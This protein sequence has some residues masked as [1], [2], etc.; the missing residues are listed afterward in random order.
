MKKSGRNGRSDPPKRR[1][2]KKIS[3]LLALPA[4]LLLSA[5]PA[6]GQGNPNEAVTFEDLGFALRL[7]TGARAA[8]LAGAYTSLGDD[9]HTLV[10][11]P[12]GLARVRRIEFSIGFQDQKK[13]LKS[14]FFGTQ[15][16]VEVTN[17]NL[18]FIA[19][20]YP[21][22]TYRG[23]FVL[24]GGVYR[25]MS[26][27][28]DILNRGTNTVTQTNDDYRLQQSGSI[29]RYN[30]GFGLDLS[31]YVSM[32]VTVFGLDGSLSALTQYSF[33]FVTPSLPG[34]LDSLVLVDDAEVDLDG[35]GATFGLQYHPMPVLHLGLSITTP[36]EVNLSGDGIQQVTEYY[37]N[38][39]DSF[40][41]LTGIIDVDYQIPFRF[42]GGVSFSPKH[43][44]V[45]F[46]VSYSDWTQARLNDLRIFDDDFRSI[47]REVWE[48]RAGVEVLL[49][50]TPVRLR[51]GYARLPYPLE[52]LQADRIE[53]DSITRATIDRESQLFAFGAGA[54]IGQ[55]LTLDLAFEYLSG[56]RA[57]PSLTD[58]RT[59]RRLLLS[60]SYR[61]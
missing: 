51:G 53:G 13:E 17:T 33:S 21:V 19:A 36:T 30:V 23:S 48:I 14:G 10:Y 32:G 58:E 22:P 31:P 61:F 26:S 43:V 38:S 46:D 47:F 55:V 8:G 49:P 34:E 50:R 44:L 20:A 3:R 27:Q 57:I 41:V 2:R 42:D 25:T 29:F 54:L 40:E 5:A 37:N 1:A 35:I 45:T 9:V 15:S 18:D 24:A 6:Y 16:D 39:P 52:Y 4:I 12:A 7:N 59:Q 11:N 28:F 56:K 60:G